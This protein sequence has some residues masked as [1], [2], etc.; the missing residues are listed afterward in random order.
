MMRGRLLFLWMDGPAHNA[1]QPFGAA[2]KRE[3]T[4][5]IS[6]FIFQLLLVQAYQGQPNITS[7]MD[8]IFGGENP[9]INAREFEWKTFTPMQLNMDGWGSNP[10]YPQALGEPTTSINRTYL[11]LKSALLPYSYSI[12]KEAVTGLPMIRAMFLD[13][14]NAIHTGQSN[15][16]SVY[17]WPIFFNCAYLSIY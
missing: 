14:P 1:M 3:A 12:A 7:D 11:K 6:V 8:G 4:G 17:V 15:P 16:I 13:E 5:N 2:I 9:V 10:K